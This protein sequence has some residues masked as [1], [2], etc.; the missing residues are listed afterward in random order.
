M[1]QYVKLV[2]EISEIHQ[3]SLIAELFEMDFTGFE[4]RGGQ[5]IT[6][7]EEKKYNHSQKKRIEQLLATYP[8]EGFIES[9]EIIADRNWNRQWEQTL[10]A[11]TIGKFFVKPT[12][13]RE[14]CP[15]NK[16]LLEIDPK[17]SFGTGYHETTRLML[18]ALPSIVT[19]GD[20]VI[21]AGTGTGILAIAAVKLGVSRVFSFDVSEWSVNNARENILLNDVADAVTVKPGSTEE[22]PDNCSADVLLANIER[23]VILSMVPDFKKVLKPEGQLLLSGLLQK[24]LDVICD[25]LG[26]DFEV[27]DIAQKNEWISIHANR[28]V[29]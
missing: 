28:I 2:I 26:D 25:R 27:T 21:D 17:M 22:I 1:M 9:E 18:E 5:I 7:I 14:K 8:Q 6:Y 29:L 23:N 12:W 19:N 4:Q 15:N 3:E 13:S 10:K 11:Q 20:H 16:I 24:D